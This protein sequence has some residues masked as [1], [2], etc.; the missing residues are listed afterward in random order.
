M[1]KKV[2]RILF[3]VVFIFLNFYVMVRPDTA[4]FQR[5][6]SAC[7]VIW[8]AMDLFEEYRELKKE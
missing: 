3:I 8:F 2:L 4:V 1:K 7:F 6:L 5:I